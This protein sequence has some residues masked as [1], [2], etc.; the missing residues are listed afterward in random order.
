MTSIVCPADSIKAA[1]TVGPLVACR[2]YYGVRYYRVTDGLR[3]VLRP[4]PPVQVITRG[5]ISGGPPA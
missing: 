1:A 4:L 2:R 3:T 5:P